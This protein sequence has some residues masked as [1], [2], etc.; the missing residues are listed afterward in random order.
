MLMSTRKD[1]LK[2]EAEKEL[3]GIDS[4]FTTCSP[5]SL[6]EAKKVIENGESILDRLEEALAEDPKDHELQGL[7]HSYREM[8]KKA[9]EELDLPKQEEIGNEENQ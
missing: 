9:R 1:A 4:L 5:L 6:E 3:P 7:A 2:R 8:T